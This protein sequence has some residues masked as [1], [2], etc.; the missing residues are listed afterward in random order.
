M[1]LLKGTH[2]FEA[3]SSVNRTVRDTVR[4]V[5]DCYME[6]NFNRF[7]FY[8]KADGFL[9]NMVRIIVGTLLEYSNEKISEYDIKNAFITGDRRLLGPT[10]Q[11]DGLYLEKVFYENDT[12]IFSEG[13]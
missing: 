12:Y 1:R 8:I 11:P 5:F 10:V 6:K 7:N 9:Y 4:T 13:V 2:N 3:F